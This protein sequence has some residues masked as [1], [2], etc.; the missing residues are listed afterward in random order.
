[1]SLYQLKPQFQN[2]LR[3]CANWLASHNVT[4]NQVTLFACFFSVSVSIF[5]AC[6]GQG[7]WWLLLPVTL[8]IRMALNAIDGMLAREHNMQSSLGLMLNEVGDLVADAAM[9]LAFIYSLVWFYWLG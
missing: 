1:M 9:Y 7:I 8:F 3:P 6:I 5:L 4:A 2:L